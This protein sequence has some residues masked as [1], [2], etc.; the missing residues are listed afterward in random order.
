MSS[1]GHE[2]EP[3]GGRIRV[4]LARAGT[5]IEN[6]LTVDADSGLSDVK[7]RALTLSAAQPGSHLPEGPPMRQPLAGSPFSRMM[8]GAQLRRFREA[9][10][11]SPEEAGYAIR[12]SRSKI[13]RMEYG[14]V[15]FKQRDVADLLT[16]HGVTDEQAR[17]GMLAL[18][19]PANA[20]GWWAEFCDVVPDWLEAYLGLE[21][22]ASLIRTF[23]PQ[24]VP[25]LF[26]TEAYARAVTALSDSA[27]SP[28][29]IRRRVRLRMKRQGLLTS[30]YPPRLWFVMDEMA[31]RRPVGTR[32][33]RRDQ[34]D[35][36]IEVAE[37]P[38][39]TPQ[40]VPF[41]PG[42]LAGTGGSL[43]ILRF[44]EGTLPDV[45]Y[46]EQLTSA[47]Y[48]EGPAHVDRYRGVITLI[49]AQALTPAD[50]TRC[51]KEISRET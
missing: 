43:T 6:A 19:R 37:L 16:L 50:T 48:L 12:T 35:H 24:F 15:G 20:A 30:P 29:E 9:A 40:V 5:E 10:H 27:A 44:G 26:Q 36:L 3:A 22:S 21:A 32:Q 7:N 8:L 1:G 38:H 11:V 23:Q 14:R 2:R 17:A 49:S 46:L 4:A 34:L 18:A 39:V 25:D 28:A 45:V 42:G 33:M 47:L 51:L 31:L 41:G 13:R